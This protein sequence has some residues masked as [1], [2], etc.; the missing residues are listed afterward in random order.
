MSET[1]QQE[2]VVGVSGSRASVAALT[3][4]ADEA[5]RRSARLSVV[6]AWDHSL[7]PAPYADTSEGHAADD[8]QATMRS[9]VAAAVRAALG[10]EPPADVETELA[11]GMPE[12]VLIGRS[13]MADLLVLGA[14]RAQDATGQPVGPVIRACLSRARCPV[15]VVVFSAG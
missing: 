13:A 3:W 5:R 4:A 1:A 7:R 2:I 6:S 11:E 14:A 12:R 10:P 9:E 15:V 8:P